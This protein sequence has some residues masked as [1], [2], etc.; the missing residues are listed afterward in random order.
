MEIFPPVIPARIRATK[1]S[2]SDW[3]MP[4]S[5]NPTAVPAMLISKTGRRPNRSDSLPRIGVKMICMPE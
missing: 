4:I 2:V 5:A 3:A 1:R